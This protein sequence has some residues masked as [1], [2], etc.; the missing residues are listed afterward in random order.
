MIDQQGL[1]NTYRESSA[2]QGAVEQRRNSHSSFCPQELTDC[3]LTYRLLKIRMLCVK[4]CQNQRRQV[5]PR[6]KAV[7][8]VVFEVGEAGRLGKD[9]KDGTLRRQG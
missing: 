6:E 9:K 5:V 1:P 4:S 2:V 8:R 7:P 3:E